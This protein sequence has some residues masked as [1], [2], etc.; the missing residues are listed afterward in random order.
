MKSLQVGSLM[1]CPEPINLSA[2]EGEAIIARLSV[3]A[4]TRSD[5]EILIL[6]VRLYFWLIFALQ[7]ASLSL[8]RLRHVLFGKNPNPREVP[9]SE[10]QA[11]PLEASEPTAAEV[12]VSRVDAVAGG[13]ADSQSSPEAVSPKVKGG[14]RAG[15]GRL[16][17]DA[18]V[19]AERVECRH[20]ELSVGQ[21]CPGCGQGNLYELPPGVEI[22]LEGHALLSALRY[23]LHKLRGS[24]CGQIFTAPLPSEAGVEKYSPRARAVLVVGRYYLGLPF[25]RLAGY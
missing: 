20:E 12:G 18:D 3:Y 2:E 13:E 15:T 19:G 17:A 23:E 21:R 11:T 4:P 16:G 9:E 22:R 8:R 1:N 5:C 7:E 24:A 10:A 6:V 14:H 25:Y